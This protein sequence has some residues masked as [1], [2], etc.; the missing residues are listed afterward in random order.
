MTSRNSRYLETRAGNRS[1]SWLGGSRTSRDL[2]V[3]ESRRKKSGKEGGL[4][5]SWKNL[6]IKGD[7]CKHLTGDPRAN[8]AT[9]G[10]SVGCL[11]GSCG[12]RSCPRS[13]CHTYLEGPSEC[14]VC[15]SCISPSR[16]GLGFHSEGLFLPAGFLEG[17]DGG[18]TEQMGKARLNRFSHGHFFLLFFFSLTRL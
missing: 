15:L 8:R 6:G 13:L 12:R 16:L 1:A 14:R 10:L 7:I 18:D 2:P 4:G 17:W 5:E 3:P 9:A 11:A